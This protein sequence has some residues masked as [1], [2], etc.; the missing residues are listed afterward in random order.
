MWCTLKKKFHVF[1]VDFTP[2]DV[3]TKYIKTAFPKLNRESKL[4]KQTSDILLEKTMLFSAIS[5]RKNFR[6][7][8]TRNSI[9]KSNL[10]N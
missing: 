10:A 9:Y 5:C 8:I 3:S 7:N 1:R 6:R 4:C 2:L